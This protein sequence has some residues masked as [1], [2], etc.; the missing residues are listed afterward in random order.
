MMFLVRASFTVCISSHLFVVVL[1]NI[2]VVNVLS[3]DPVVKPLRVDRRVGTDVIA[4]PVVVDIGV[5]L[6][7]PL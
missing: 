5:E 3:I 4:P 2:L 7:C 1:V 6:G